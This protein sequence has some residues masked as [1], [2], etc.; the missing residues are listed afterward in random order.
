MKKLFTTVLAFMAAVC[1]MAQGWPENYGGVMLQGFYWDY[2]NYEEEMNATGWATWKGLESHASDLEGYIDLIWVPN[3][4]RTKNDYCVEHAATEGNGWLKDMGYMPCWWLNHD[5]TIFGSATDLKSMIAT[6]KAKGIGIIEDVVINHKN[7]QN[8]WCDFPNESVT[9][10]YGSYTLDWTL[11]DI[12]Y[13]DNGGQCRAEG[14]D[15]TGAA[16]TGDDFDGCR[17]LD[18]T[19]ANVQKNVKTYL[20]YLQ[21]ELGYTGFRYDMVKGYGP[22][23]VGVYNTYAKPTF[24]VGECWDNWKGVTDWING[25]TQNNVVQ[26]AAFDFPLKFLINDAFNGSFDGSKLDTQGMAGDNY[27]KRYS[28][29]FVDNHDTYRSE[30]IP[31]SNTHHVLAAN[32]FILAMP[33]T[34]CIF[35]P[36]WKEYTV[37]LKNMIAARKAAGITNT[38][39]FKKIEGLTGGIGFEVTGTN[40]KVI[41]TLGNV[42]GYSPSGYNIVESG[43]A[44]NNDFCF[45]VENTVTIPT[46]PDKANYSLGIPCVDMASGTYY[47]TV[48][49]NVSPSDDFTTLVYT[50][51]GTDPTI[52]S[53]SITA[54]GKTFTFDTEDTYTL[55]VGV[56]GTSGV[57]DI[58]TYRYVVTNEEP[59]DITIYVR[60]DKEPIYLYAWDENGTLTSEWPGTQL[61]AKK[62]AD[63]V[64]FYYMTF[65]K[66]SADY[67]LNYIL[68][69]GGD[70]TKTP[71][72]TGIGSTIF[73]S[74]G[75]GAAVDLTAT[76]AGMPIKDPV[77]AGELITVYVKGDF[78][79][80]YLYTWDGADLGAWPGTKM[81]TTLI[82]GET[83]FYHTMSEG[84]TSFNMKVNEGKNMP[85][86]NNYVSTITSTVYLQ[87]NK[88][89]NDLE[90]VNGMAEYPREAWYEQGEI[91]AFFVIPNG[92]FNGWNTICAYAYNGDTK[93]TEIWEGTSRG[94]A[95]IRLGR[96][97]NGDEI[98]KWTCTKNVTGQPATIIFNSASENNKTEDLRFVN[99]AWYSAES[100]NGSGNTEPISTAVAPSSE[101]SLAD[102]GISTTATNWNGKSEKVAENNGNNSM[103]K[104]FSLAAGSYIVQAIVRGTNNST[105]T[106]SAKNESATVALKGLDGA[107]SS[108]QPNGIV[109][110]YATGANNGWKKVEVAFTLTSA[111]MVTVTLSSSA[112]TWQLGA[113]KVLPGTTKTKATTD[114]DMANTF[115][116]VTGE[117]EFSFYERGQNRNA[118]IKATAGTLPALLPYNVIVDG[119]CANLKLADGN[120]SFNNS[121][122]D[123]TAS[124]ASYDRTFVPGKRSTICLPFALNA[125]EAAAAGTFWEM[126][127]Y[128]SETGN[129]RFVEV[130]E[131]A[132]NTPYI[133]EAATAQPFLSIS[134]KNVPT[135]SLNPVEV[136]GISFVGVNERTNL[137]SVTNGT[138]YYGYKNNE[139]VKVGT[140][141]GANINPFRAYLM[142]GSSM[143]ARMSVLF[144]D[145]EG[146]MTG[147]Q[148]V[149]PAVE[150]VR[151]QPIFNL[152]GQR[153]LTPNKK[154][155]Y[156]I[157][158]KKYFVK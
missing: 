17:D 20:D 42:T 93:Y 91:C 152:S 121:G 157:G 146:G 84:V 85:E 53:S 126:D 66:T 14:N 2:Y 46:T 97:E 79:P 92:W 101:I 12:C 119:T 45:Y 128:N 9:G 77:E 50:E 58:Q 26:S 148:D 134:G 80:A 67:T 151:Q 98:W 1:V 130:E 83:W 49:V 109:E 18:H 103:T 111:E 129:I 115:I 55:K 149:T 51:D 72:Q 63:G 118:L 7:G 76:Y 120:Y 96:N 56:L 141:V 48:T 43:D 124:A 107:T 40:G 35:L 10:T 155:L 139:F 102:L 33:G 133:F 30:S 131:P 5:N 75:N 57:R 15:V 23:F 3:S 94:D 89:N 70:D 112:A 86:S 100:W 125:A 27:Y 117:T 123:F 28:V 132:A 37:A 69:Q 154:G 62:S 13:N 61:S 113:L 54:G 137:K 25:T 47:Q 44:T 4:A 88:T 158:G 143:G 144:D 52:N 71:D 116:D 138:T 153:V 11:A 106:L 108:V 104:D 6:Y 99:G 127:S 64:N 156:I 73:T 32:A 24:S 114:V 65:P 34:P 22:Q 41:V 60:A 135:S 145:E 105:L 122:N 19:G 31:L 36:H 136:N 59:T 140:D 81:S 82:N 16:D 21:K 29:T 68:N 110:A 8:Q 142:T 147:I 74:L 87:W 95:C 39:G 38:S 78:G 90:V 150:P